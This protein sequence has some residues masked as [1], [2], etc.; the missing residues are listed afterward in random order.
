MPPN[1]RAAC[2]GNIP[3]R[4]G[5][6]ARYKSICIELSRPIGHQQAGHVTATCE[7]IQ[8]PTENGVLRTGTGS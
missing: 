7:L 4:N 3:F 1:D 8:W 2:S 5:R 6:A